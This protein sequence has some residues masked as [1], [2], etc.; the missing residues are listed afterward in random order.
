MYNH[1]L[2]EGKIFLWIAYRLP[3]GSSWITAVLDIWPVFVVFQPQGQ[4]SLWGAF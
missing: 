4:G 2:S 1:F 3:G